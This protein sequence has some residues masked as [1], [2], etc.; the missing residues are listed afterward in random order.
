MVQ[1]I[2]KFLKENQP[3][4]KMQFAT[5]LKAYNKILFAEI[6][7]QNKIKIN[8]INYYYNAKQNKYIKVV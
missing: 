1:I 6:M 2:N 4:K 5:Q 3:N 8:N 7:Q